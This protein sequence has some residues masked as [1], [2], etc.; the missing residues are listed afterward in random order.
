MATQAP[1]VFATATRATTRRPPAAWPPLAL[2][3]VCAAAY[4]T[5]FVLPYYA[6]DL[7]RLPLAEVASGMHDPKDLWPRNEAG[8]G[9]V[10]TFGGLLTLALAPFGTIFAVGWAAL[11]VVLG[12]P[13]RDGLTVAISALAGT[14]G[15]VTLV[16]LVSP[17]ASALFAWWLD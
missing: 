8:L 10:F 7:N 16:W 14:I 4:A 17:F 2:A 11:N 9:F 1:A 12:R 3:V 5:F 13:S 6:N 15:I